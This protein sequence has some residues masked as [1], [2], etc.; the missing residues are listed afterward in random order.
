[1]SEYIDPLV[2]KYFSPQIAD[3]AVIHDSCQVADGVEISAKTVLEKDVHIGK[4]VK[5]VGDVHLEPD[6]IT[7]PF[8]ILVGPLRIGTASI[9]GTGVVIGMAPA[10]T[11]SRRTR[12]MEACRVGR[13]AQIMAGVQVGQH[14]RIRAGSVVTGDV[15]HYG[16]ASGAPAVLEAYACPHCGGLLSQVRLM[17]GAVDAHCET[18]DAGEHRFAHQF[19]NDAFNKVLLPY[20]S[21]GN[22]V[23]PFGDPRGWKDEEEIEIRS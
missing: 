9:I 4:Y 5:I 22:H 17:R 20:H 7:H 21:F 8:S 13:G 23:P 12:L 19:W 1:M 3:G 18:C 6:V 2:A 14:A 10:D 11:D 16:L 15:P